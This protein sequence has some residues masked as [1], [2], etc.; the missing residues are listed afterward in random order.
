L[1]KNVWV[2]GF[3]G[4]PGYV[5]ALVCDSVPEPA[6]PLRDTVIEV[7]TGTFTAPNEIA[8]DELLMVPPGPQDVV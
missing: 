5:A 2:G 1:K 6:Y 3:G 4:E 8:D 7:P